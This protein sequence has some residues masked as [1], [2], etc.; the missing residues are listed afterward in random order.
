MTRIDDTRVPGAAEIHRK[1]EKLLRQAAQK[2]QGQEAG[3]MVPSVKRNTAN[4]GKIKEEMKMAEACRDF[5]AL[6][7]QQMFSEMRRGLNEGSVLGEDGGSLAADRNRSSFFR[8]KMYENISK[9]MANQS[10]F[11]IGS[12]LFEQLYRQEN[13]D[14]LPSAE[15]S[16]VSKNTG[17]S[18]PVAGP[19]DSVAQLL[20]QQKQTHRQSMSQ[21]QLS[22]FF[23]K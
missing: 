14:I 15:S 7:I 1:Y 12:V 10:G 18:G 21:A 16:E 8:D 17:G 11:G 19:A 13:P 5:E 6:F 23:Y 3:R 4:S 9:D 20:E 2:E 22:N